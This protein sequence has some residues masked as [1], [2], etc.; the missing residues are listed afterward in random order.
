MAQDAIFPHGSIPIQEISLSLRLH[1]YGAARTVTGSCFLL[2]TEAARVLV[3]CGMF[4][5]SKEEREL[6]YQHFPFRAAGISALCLTHAHI[7]HSG[8][9]PKLVKAGFDGPIYATSGTTDLA[10]IML[11]DSG[12]IQEVEVNQLNRR[13]SRR[14]RETVT[15]IYTEE[16]AIASLR[17]F[18]SVAYGQWQNVAP[19]FRARYWNAGHLLGSASIEME[20]APNGAK[21]PIRFLFSGDV[22]PDHKL[23]QPDPDGPSNLD[24]VILESTYGDTD[25]DGTTIERRR[26]MLRDEVRAAMKPSGALLIPSFAVERTQELL[27]DLMELMEAGELPEIPIFIDSPLASKASAIFKRHA[28]ELRNGSD[29]VQALESRFVR[30]TETVEQSKAI[31]RIHSF[32]I[33]IAASGMCEAGRIRHH[34]KAWLWRDEATVLFVGFQAQGT[35]GRILQDGASKVRIHGEEVNVRA[36][37]RT[38]DLYSGHADGPELKAWLVDRLP[39]R[40]GVFLVHGE[41]PALKALQTSLADIQHVPHPVIPEI[42]DIYDLSGET[43]VR[44][45]R[46]EPRLPASSAGHRDWHNDYAELMLE[47]N[48][49]IDAAADRKAKAVVIRRIREAL[50]DGAHG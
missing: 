11:P 20:V 12:Y 26:R 39:V 46:R 30:F 29:L 36:R 15:P 6:N 4:Q 32:H 7:D 33:I 38:L 1:F 34:L 27:V 24:Y 31:D 14:G 35:L 48:E 44:V 28:K 50:K 21:E 2:E 10:S 23:L 13:N 49:A 41:D 19:G 8:L 25:R 17:Q 42:D 37:L 3:D 9:V 5:G 18:R 47:I 22:G 45:E 43:A 16:D 40:R